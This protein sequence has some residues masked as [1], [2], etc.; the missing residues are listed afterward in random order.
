MFRCT[1]NENEIGPW[2]IWYI[3]EGTSP[4]YQLEH[5]IN[6]KWSCVQCCKFYPTGRMCKCHDIFTEQ[7]FKSCQ[8]LHDEDFNGEEFNG[9]DDNVDDFNADDGNDAG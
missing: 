8:N 4:R 5:M 1:P 6:G 2:N 3:V 7:K 9:I